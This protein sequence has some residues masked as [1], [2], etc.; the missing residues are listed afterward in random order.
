MAPFVARKSASAPPEQAT[1]SRAGAAG[2]STRAASTHSSRRVSSVRMSV[3][4]LVP[5]PGA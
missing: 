4:G 3:V 1:A 2:V 5:Y